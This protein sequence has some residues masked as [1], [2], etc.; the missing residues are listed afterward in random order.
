MIHVIR[1]VKTLEKAAWLT[2]TAAGTVHMTEQHASV[3]IVTRE[4]IVIHRIRKGVM[5]ITK[6]IS[7][8]PV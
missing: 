6:N 5:K 2:I 3:M 8:K 1:D 4:T 7:P